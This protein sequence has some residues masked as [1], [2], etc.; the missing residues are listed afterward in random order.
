MEI[1]IIE[2]LAAAGIQ[3]I[4]IGIALQIENRPG[5]VDD[6]GIILHPQGAGASVDN[7]AVVGD[8]AANQGAGA[9][10]GKFHGAAHRKAAV[11]EDLPV[12]KVENS[13][14]SYRPVPLQVAV[15]V[16]D[17]HAH[18]VLHGDAAAADL[19]TAVGYLHQAAAAEGDAVEAEGGL[20]ELDLPAG[21]GIHGAAARGIASPLETQFPAVDDN[22]AAIVKQRIHDGGAAAP[23]LD[24][25]AVIVKSASAVRKNKVHQFI[26][27]DLKGCAGAVEDLRLVMQ[28]DETVVFP[29]DGA[30]VVEGVADQFLEITAG[31]LQHRP[32]ADH[33]TAAAFLGAPEPL[34]LAGDG[35]GGVADKF[36]VQ[37]EAADGLVAGH[38]DHPGDD[39]CRIAHGGHSRGI[40]VGGSFPNAGT[41]DP[42]AGLLSVYPVEGCKSG[43]KN[44]QEENNSACRT[45]HEKYLSLVRLKLI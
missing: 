13:I 4:D 32:A 29:D 15:A 36:S 40:P 19:Q 45:E 11:A 1:A 2:D 14:D 25:G 6:L 33:S 12:G 5:S 37:P 17:G 9:A 43:E 30:L 44:H 39:H 18:A 42:G 35:Q 26:I 28:L 41:P 27:L 8:G 20:G 23:A 34:H 31:D 7:T 3:I 10:A 16:A 24:Q 38:G 22:A 21:G